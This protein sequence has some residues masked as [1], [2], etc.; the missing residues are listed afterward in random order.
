MRCLGG[1]DPAQPQALQGW[2]GTALARFGTGQM[3]H[4]PGTAHARRHWPGPGSPAALARR[5]WPVTALARR[6]RHAA[7]RP[8]A[9]WRARGRR[10]RSA[11]RRGGG[12]RAGDLV[13]ELRG[14]PERPIDECAPEA[15]ELA[16]G[17]EAGEGRGGE[18]SGD[19]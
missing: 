17:R 4:W 3:R 19:R 9:S 15:R 10:G 1:D 13:E 2:P 5:Q 8:D 14:R 6:Y 7:A 18:A 12:R 11:R 16:G